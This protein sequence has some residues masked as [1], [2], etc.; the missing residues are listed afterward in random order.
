VDGE[1]MGDDGTV[2][3]LFFFRDHDKNHL[4]IVQE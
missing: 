3:A 2:P 4:M 1:I